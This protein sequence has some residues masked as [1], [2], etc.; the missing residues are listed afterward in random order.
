MDFNKFT[1]P[2]I[3]IL[4]GSPRSG[5][6]F[7]IEYLIYNL[8]KRGKFHWG[9][10]FSPTAIKNGSYSFMPID[11]V[12]AAP[13][14]YKRKDAD[15][16]TESRYKEIDKIMEYQ[17]KNPGKSTFIIFDDCNGLVNWYL[18]QLIN[19]I[20][21]YRH[22]RISLFIASQQ[23][24]LATSP[25]L[26]GCATYGFCWF[27]NIDNNVVA[28]HKDFI[29]LESKQKVKD[30]LNKYCPSKSHIFIFVDTD[31]HEAKQRYRVT[32]AHEVPKFSL[33]F[34]AKL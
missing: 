21:T 25:L 1:I 24:T 23:I 26:R 5:K 28:M 18:P 12:I 9:T 10:V 15:G 31:E 7:T 4:F 32:K 30:W 17:A 19:L 11:R 20:S 3:S 34:D 2:S 22:Q 13:T 33:K 14:K 29:T 27:Q 6:T 8:Y 16:N